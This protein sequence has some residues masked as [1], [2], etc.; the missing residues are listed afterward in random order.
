MRV[1]ALSPTRAQCGQSEAGEDGSFVRS[2]RSS[3]LDVGRG[4]V[5]LLGVV[6]RCIEDGMG[7]NGQPL[8]GFNRTA[9]VC[10]SPYHASRELEVDN[11]S[12]GRSGGTSSTR[13]F[14]YGVMSADAERTE[15]RGT[16][17]VNAEPAGGGVSR[18][19]ICFARWLTFCDEGWV[20]VLTK[21]CGILD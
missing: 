9:A 4:L 12:G 6:V 13:Q 2:A 8:I 18:R 14:R 15:H 20:D 17:D 16:T 1:P 10:N 19:A 21:K 7:G 5:S 11:S 3:V